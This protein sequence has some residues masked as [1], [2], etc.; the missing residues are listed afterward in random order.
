MLIGYRRISKA[1][2]SQVLD[3]QTDALLAYG[4]QEQHIYEDKQSRA[5]EDRDGL[6]SCIKSL[7]PGDTLVVWRLDRLGGKLTH[8]IKLVEDLSAAGINFKVLAGHGCHI[9]TSTADGKL[10]F[11]IFA[12]LCEFEREIIRER[13]NAGL[14]AFRKRG[15]KS[16][17]RLALKERD[18]LYAQKV[19]AEKTMVVKDLCREIGVSPR[20]LYRYVGPNGELRDNGRK[21]LEKNNKAKAA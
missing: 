2:G 5:K 1:D 21:V 16:G 9:D 14:E 15:G 18:I 3:L 20:T 17:R 7:R 4:V 8:L 6:N 19:M 12:A 10:I 13:V 11:S